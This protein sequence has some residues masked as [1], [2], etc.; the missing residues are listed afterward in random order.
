MSNRPYSAYGVIL[1]SF[2]LTSGVHAQRRTL[3]NSREEGIICATEL[4]A[5][6]DDP[7]DLVFD[8]SFSSTTITTHVRRAIKVG[9]SSD[10]FSLA[11]PSNSKL[12]WGERHLKGIHASKWNRL[13]RAL[14]IATQTLIDRGISFDEYEVATRATGSEKRTAGYVVLFS[15][16]KPL[17]A[18]GDFAIVMNRYYGNVRLVKGH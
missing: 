18:G 14:V 10:M 7:S 11:V 16:M 4:A 13:G 17:I 15:P 5:E 8:L 3:P 9:N 2:L 12:P 6:M 1:I